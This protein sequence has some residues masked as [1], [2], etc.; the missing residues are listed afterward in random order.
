MEN[1]K[2]PLS[3]LTHVSPLNNTPAQICLYFLPRHKLS[4]A[5]HCHHTQRRPRSACCIHS[6]F[7][8]A[9]I[10]PSSPVNLSRSGF[11]ICSGASSVP[12]DLRCQ[13]QPDALAL[14]CRRL[15]RGLS[16][17]FPQLAWP[18]MLALPSVPHLLSEP[19]AD[20]LL[21]RNPLR[22]PC[23]HNSAVYILQYKSLERSISE[24]TIQRMS[25]FFGSVLPYKDENK[26]YVMHDL[27]YL[28]MTFNSSKH[29]SSWSFDEKLLLQS[30]YKSV[31]NDDKVEQQLGNGALSLFV[32]I[33]FVAHASERISLHLDSS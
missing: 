20:V 10:C 4:V 11:P 2:P 6:S 3:T 28:A 26:G 23:L 15:L 24:P 22:A 17:L 31:A 14:L 29:I 12:R 13:L 30:L 16:P 27:S 18:P 7:K 33:K 19:A 21:S 1:P 9:R 32:V 5:H 25:S 8:S